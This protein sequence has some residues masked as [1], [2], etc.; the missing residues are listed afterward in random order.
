MVKL[1][2]DSIYRPIAVFGN[3]SLEHRV[4]LFETSR[5]SGEKNIPIELLIAKNR[6]GATGTVNLIFRKNIGSFDN[7]INKEEENE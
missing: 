3:I 1:N 5:V 2:I 4:N 6:A 7:Y